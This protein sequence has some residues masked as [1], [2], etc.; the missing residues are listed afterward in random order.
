[1]LE[2]GL[3]AQGVP[4]SPA[5]HSWVLEVCDSL[6]CDGKR[7]DGSALNAISID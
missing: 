6:M 7:R 5:A 4:Q 1:M 3:S 2:T